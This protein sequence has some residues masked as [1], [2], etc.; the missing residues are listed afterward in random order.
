LRKRNG[1]ERPRILI[2]TTA[3]LQANESRPLASVTKAARSVSIACSRVM[4]TPNSLIRSTA[5][6]FWR[7]LFRPIS[8]EVAPHP[9]HRMYTQFAARLSNVP[10]LYVIPQTEERSTRILVWSF[11]ENHLIARVKLGI[12]DCI[13]NS[14]WIAEHTRSTCR[15]NPGE[16]RG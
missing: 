7:K 3:F 4:H 15:R 12:V 9:L 8:L 6:S 13:R 16:F 2:R 10:P 5:Q 14:V 11:S 1:A